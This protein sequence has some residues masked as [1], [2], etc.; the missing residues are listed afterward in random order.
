[1]HLLTP[2]E[3]AEINGA[4]LS[5]DV[6][7][8]PFPGVDLDISAF[9]LTAS[10]RVRTDDDMCFYG[11]S[12]CG[13]GSLILATNEAGKSTF[14][15][16]TASV[17]DDVSTIAFVATVYENKATISA[18]PEIKLSLG[19]T[20]GTAVKG[21]GRTESAIILGELYRRNGTWKFRSVLAGYVG[22]LA[23]LARHFGVSIKTDTPPPSSKISLVKIVEQKA[24]K[25][26]N[27]AK[28]ADAVIEKQKLSTTVAR[29]ALVLDA[30]GSMKKQ[31]REGRVQDLLNRLLPLAAQFDDD[32][33]IDCWAFGN[34]TQ[35][36]GPVTFS[37]YEH[38]TQTAKGGWEAWD[39]GARTNN[40]PEVIET[41]F[42]HYRN[43][44]RDVPVYVLF[45]SDGGI[46]QNRRIND[47]I[48]DGAKR[49]IF[50]QFLGLAGKDYGILERLDTMK[51]RLVDNC[52]FFAIDDLHDISEE[53]L[54]ARMLNEFPH[55]LREAK[56]KGVLESV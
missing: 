44:G 41:V 16:N 49:P 22:G 21:T 55:W 52:G 38:F 47:L 2:G 50:W 28:K 34:K 48:T 8:Q 15:V 7:Y 40:E 43:K 30:S 32:Q 11:Q 56:S 12:N 24:P 45:V 31:Y 46:T 20:L 5:I 23:E 37:N 27:L 36:I 53:E 14:N 26:I 19:Q 4:N 39:L 33:E 1:M 25:L 13:S 42:K 9:L 6:R 10:G 51:G 17:P 18:Y 35:K 3:N 29:V 54:Y